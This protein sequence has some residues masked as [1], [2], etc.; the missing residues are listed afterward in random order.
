MKHYQAAK[1]CGR[2][3]IVK[4]LRKM[5][6]IIEAK[7]KHVQSTYVNFEINNAL[8]QHLKD[9]SSPKGSTS[10]DDNGGPSSPDDSGE[11]NM[12]VSILYYIIILLF[13]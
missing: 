12:A 9:C 8:E 6:Y 7:L 1:N 2:E 13:K 10:V 11:S 5:L 3:D 4:E